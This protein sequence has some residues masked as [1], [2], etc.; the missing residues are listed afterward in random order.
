MYTAS[1]KELELLVTYGQVQKNNI[2]NRIPRKLLDC[3]S[4]LMQKMKRGGNIFSK[5][6]RLQQN[7]FMIRY[8]VLIVV[9]TV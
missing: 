1:D 2:K 4:L 8:A 7:L 6:K 9:G 3:I 5:Y